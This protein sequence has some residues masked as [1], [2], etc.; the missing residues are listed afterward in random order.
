M[1]RH[2]GKAADI[3]GACTAAVAR[4]VQWTE[5]SRSNQQFECTPHLPVDLRIRPL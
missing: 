1:A 5:N 3:H 2:R 4:L